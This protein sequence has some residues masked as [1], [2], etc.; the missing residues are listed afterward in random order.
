LKIAVFM[1]AQEANLTTTDHLFR[2]LPWI[3]ANLKRI[4]FGAAFVLIAV[5][6]FSFYSYRQNQ[7][8]IAAG[9][10]LTQAGISGG[11]GQLAEACLKIATEY[12]GTPAG[13]RAL[14]QGATVLFTT[15]KYADAQTQFQKFLDTYPDNFLSPQATLGVAAS[16][17]ALGKTD[18]AVSAYQK[19]ASQTADLSVVANAKFSLARIDETQGKLAEA[20]KLYGEVARTYAN[21]SLGSEAGLRAM[22]LNAKLPKAPAPPAPAAGVPFNLGK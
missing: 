22:E 9:E 3:E 4:A 10:A 19:A 17:D 6:I 16:L 11:G 18:L 8:E 1:Q 15:G 20:Q 5:F 7:R 2:L 12:A 14:L 21:T 13:Q